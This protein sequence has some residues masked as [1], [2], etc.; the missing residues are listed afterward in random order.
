VS[1]VSFFAGVIGL[2]MLVPILLVGVFTPGYVPSDALR[3]AAGLGSDPFRARGE[4]VR[5]FRHRCR[6]Q[7]DMDRI[8]REGSETLYSWEN[9]RG[10]LARTTISCVA[11]GHCSIADQALVA[12]PLPARIGGKPIPTH[13]GSCGHWH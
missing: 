2:P 11:D 7:W 1:R 9:D 13:F 4:M 5:S 10:F 3:R 6:G 12:W 8:G